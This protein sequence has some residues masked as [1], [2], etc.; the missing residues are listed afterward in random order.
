MTYTL[1][2]SISNLIDKVSSEYRYR[3]DDTGDRD[4]NFNQWVRIAEELCA[5]G[6][7][8][9]EIVLEDTEIPDATQIRKYIKNDTLSFV[10]MKYNF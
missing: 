6:L 9:K 3:F 8:E 4:E 1:F 5:N 10:I 2:V 7:Q